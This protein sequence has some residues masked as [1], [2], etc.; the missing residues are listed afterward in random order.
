M[1]IITAI[2]KKIGEVRTESIDLSVGEIVALHENKELVIQPDFQRLFRW[3]TEQ[4]SRLVESMLLELPIPSIFVIEREDGVLEL[5]DG[6]QRVSSLIQFVSSNAL[7]LQ[8]LTLDG[9]DLVNELNGMSFDI[10]PLTLRLRLKRTGIRTVVIKRQ[11]SQFLRYEMFKRL[12]TGGAKLSEQ[13]IRNVN[14]RMI[15]D[16][17]KKFYDFLASCSSYQSFLTTTDLLSTAAVDARAR[18]E[19]VLRFFAVM[20]YREKFKG[21]ISEWLDN[22]ME[23][24]IIEGMIF[25]YNSQKSNFE[26]LFD[27]LAEKFGPYAFVKYRS[28]KPV[29][30][31]AP[32]YY[33]AVTAGCFKNL[34]KLESL[35][36]TAAIDKLARVVASDEFREV[37]G[38]GANSL[39]KLER[40]IA[41]VS[42]EFTQ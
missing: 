8:P 25:D 21:S 35:T 19:L 12:N 6:L 18:E 37:T 17:G 14:A 39:P 20:N 15:G 29:G 4:R 13:D 42:D 40:R 2:D 41:I 33:E 27:I 9:C 38:P 30:G 11:S 32:A 5:I 36:A 16:E 24:I 7:G 10:L 26:K 1:E 31:L 28:G 22:Y 23:K 3:S 34:A